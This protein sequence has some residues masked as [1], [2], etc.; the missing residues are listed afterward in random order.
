MTD[1]RYRKGLQE[2]GDG[3]WAYLQ[4]DG[5]WGW[6]NA[7]LVADGDQSLL[8]DTLF[9]LN[10]TRGMLAD[11]RRATAAAQAIGQVVNTHANGDHCWG[12]QL[13]GGA[14]IIASKRG[15]LEMADVPAAMLAQLMAAAPTMGDLGTYLQRIF[16]DFD[17]NGIDM[18]LP[19][20]TFEGDMTCRVGDKDVRLIEVGPA[21]TQGDVLVHVPADRVLYSGDILFIEGHPVMWAGPVGNWIAACDRILGMDLDVIVPGHGPITDKAGVIQ[22]RDYLAYLQTESRLRYDAG[23][24]AEEAARDI[25]LDAYAGWSDAERICV[26]V[27]TLY[28]EFSGKQTEFDVIALFTDMARFAHERGLH[29]LGD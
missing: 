5:S 22:L 17:F 3:V 16:G 24:P 11:M 7:G 13:V 27:K 15:A 4:P 28:G 6:S 21:H 18:V 9:D 1:W 20:K 29:G 12:N 8:V 10:L 26:N 23:M 19:T 14:E 25:A 2:V